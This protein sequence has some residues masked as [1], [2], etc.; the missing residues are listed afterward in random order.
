MLNKCITDSKIYLEYSKRLNE[1]LLK[2]GDITIYDRDAFTVYFE[3][4]TE[5]STKLY[6]VM[7]LGSENKK[8]VI[9]KD[10]ILSVNCKNLIYDVN[11]REELERVLNDNLDIISKLKKFRD[12]F[13]HAPHTIKAKV[14]GSNGFD[15]SIKIM[16]E[17]TSKEM[18][19]DSNGLRNLLNCLNR[20]LK[21]YVVNL[22]LNTINN[23]DIEFKKSNYPLYEA[24]FYQMLVEITNTPYGKYIGKLNIT[25]K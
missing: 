7:G 5:F 18:S 23:F 11:L 20:F 1:I 25:V 21:K 4:L 12:K 16:D 19:V 13:Q 24:N 14:L 3:L 2:L 9:N 15:Y 17:V 22:A 6:T 10:G 8:I